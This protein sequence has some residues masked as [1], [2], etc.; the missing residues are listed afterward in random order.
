MN[1][2][3]SNPKTEQQ[4]LKNFALTPHSFT[5]LE[6][7]TL[8]N[9]LRSY[10]NRTPSDHL[11]RIWISQFGHLENVPESLVR[12]QLILDYLVQVAGM[13]LFRATALW[14]D[15]EDEEYELLS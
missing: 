6:M 13:D 12:D 1:I 7:V 10:R 4:A 5:N 9:A 15:W 14:C 8:S 2:T 3:Y 11:K